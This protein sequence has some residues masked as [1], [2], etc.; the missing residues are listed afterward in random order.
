MSTIPNISPPANLQPKKKFFADMGEDCINMDAAIAI[1]KVTDTPEA[2][3][4]YRAFRK[5]YAQ[6]RLA[7]PELPEQKVRENAVLAA[8]EDCGHRITFTPVSGTME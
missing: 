2:K 6:M 7:S 8:I 3:A 1:M 5:R 4:I